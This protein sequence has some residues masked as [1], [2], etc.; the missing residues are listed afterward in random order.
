[1]RV[2]LRKGSVHLSHTFPF[3][4]YA[5]L[6]VPEAEWQVKRTHHYGHRKLP[7]DPQ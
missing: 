5:A 4:S 2:A 7:Q 1:M 6:L 3:L